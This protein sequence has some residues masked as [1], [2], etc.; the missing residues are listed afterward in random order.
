MA[1]KTSNRVLWVAF[2]IAALAHWALRDLP[3]PLNQALRGIVDKR[4]E[5]KEIP[6]IE[7]EKWDKQKR[8]VQSSKAAKED[9]EAKDKEAH[10]GGE[11]RNRVSKETQSPFRGRFAEGAPRPIPRQP[12]GETGEDGGQPT[13]QDL[14]AF[15]GSPHALRDDVQP[16][17]QTVLNTDPVKYAGFINRIADKIYNPWVSFA[18]EAVGRIYD[19]GKTLEANT[20]ITKLQVVMD[21]DGSVRA[22]QTV[23]SSGVEELDEAPKKAFWEV[24]PFTNPPGQMFKKESVVRFIYEFHFEWRNSGFSIIPSPI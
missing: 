21:S 19:G 15:G 17:N 1:A 16:G 18:R 8:I 11:F 14:M 5:E 9:A 10:Y 12:S 24:E 23:A 20:Y 6:P 7:L 13:L 22:I 3:S 2:L 4:T